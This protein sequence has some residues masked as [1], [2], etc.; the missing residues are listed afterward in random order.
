MRLP[1][2]LLLSVSVMVVP[3][4]AQQADNPV[5]GDQYHIV[6]LEDGVLRIDRQTGDISECNETQNGWVCR[7]SAD[8]RLA[9]EAEI[10][11]LDAEVDSLQEELLAARQAPGENFSLAPDSDAD[12][13]SSVRER[14]D[15]PTDEELDAVIDTAEEV[16]RR[17][18][19][20][21]EGLREDLEAER[22]Q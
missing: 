12:D 19:G 5:N 10:N 6:E 4:I 2:A 1:L 20:M 13:P 17:F 22:N 7:L 8:D 21:V 9:Y 16:M 11:R 3:A 18:F 14:L 15:L